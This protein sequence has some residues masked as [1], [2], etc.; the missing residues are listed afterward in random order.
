MY[1][2]F[3]NGWIGKMDE[4]WS[5]KVRE[6]LF[7]SLVSF[8][9]KETSPGQKLFISF[10][11]NQTSK[12]MALE[13]ANYFC[14]YGIPVFISNRPISTSMVQVISKE[15]F[16]CGSLS[17]VNDDYP[18]PYIGLK[19]STSEGTFLSDRN[20][21]D[22]QD[23]SVTKKTQL[24]WFDPYLN[25]KHYIETNFDIPSHSIPID[26]LVW[27]AMFSP[28]SPI[29]EELFTDVFNKKSIDAYS[30]NSFESSLANEI[31][32]EIDM[33]E[34][35]DVTRMMMDHFSTNYGITTS[36]DLTK[37]DIQRLSTNNVSNVEIEEIAKR[38]FPYLK[39]KDKLIISD[40]ISYSSEKKLK[41]HFTVKKVPQDKFHSTLRNE[42]FSLAIDDNGQIYLQ[43]ELFANQ[44]ATL[45]FLLHSFIFSSKNTKNNDIKDE[46]KENA[47][48]VG[49]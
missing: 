35:L 7:S 46:N 16:G 27:N 36:P 15:R 20:L 31:K 13:A 38:V 47:G 45:F 25:L 12:Y 33:Q 14:T 23:N 5:R 34:Q 24:E 32:I 4:T 30:I 42:Y 11:H 48:G 6:K 19:A 18:F 21:N 41:D 39:T 29:L 43:N 2:S 28:S 1:S 10:D 8:F 22:S 3:F 9:R 37:I 40:R 49:L 17:F 44:F 26:S